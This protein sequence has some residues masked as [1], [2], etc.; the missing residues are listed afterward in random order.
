MVNFIQWLHE[1]EAKTTA[2][3]AYGTLVNHHKKFGIDAMP[4]H[5]EFNNLLNKTPITKMTPY[6]AIAMNNTSATK[7]MIGKGITNPSVIKGAGV[8]DQRHD[9]WQSIKYHT[10][11]TENTPIVA[12]KHDGKVTLLD[13]DHRVMA[14]VLM[15]HPIMVKIMRW[16]Q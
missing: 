9:S 11:K 15:N 1:N 5:E 4:S 2:E 7:G 12:I 3:D 16:N 13:G 8:E 6:Q 10:N 14:A